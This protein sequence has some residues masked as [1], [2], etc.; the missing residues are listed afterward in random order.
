MIDNKFDQEL[1]GKIKKDHIEPIPR[2]HF[3]LK[4][5]IVWFFGILSLIVGGLAFSIVIYLLAFNDWGIYSQIDESFLEFVLLT[6]PYFWIL[7]LVFFGF[8]VYHNIKHTKKGYK[9]SFKSIMI[10]NVVISV[11]LGGLFFQVGIGQALDDALGETVPVYAKVLNR[12]MHFWSQPEK[13]RL[14]GLVVSVE[15]EENF[16][17][18]DL[19]QN[20]WWVVSKSDYRGS[21]EVGRPVKI[22]GNVIGDNQFEAKRIMKPAPPGK[23]MFKRHKKRH[24]PTEK[25]REKMHE[26]MM[27]DPMFKERFE[28]MREGLD[29]Y[30]ELK[31]R[32]ENKINDRE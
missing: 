27:Q 17:L 9:Y 7:F 2:W 4:D 19:H 18:L 16:T 30:P 23:G 32:L 10:A 24:L 3:L 15:N 31:E 1:L 29:K 8:L 14:S 12:Q 21:V 25:E 28:K 22:L 26:R 6:M 11:V 13:G 5:Y 20:E